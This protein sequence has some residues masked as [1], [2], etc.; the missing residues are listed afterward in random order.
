M[1]Y[2]FLVLLLLGIS[3][4]GDAALP[5]EQVPVTT[6]AN[7]Q[8]AAPTPPS[9]PTTPITTAPQP[10]APSPSTTPEGDGTMTMENLD[11]VQVTMNPSLFLSSEELLKKVQQSIIPVYKNWVL[12]KN[13]TY[14]ILDDVSNIPDVAQ[15]ALRLLAT[16]RPKSVL[17]K[18]TWDYSISHL[19]RV[20]GWSVYGNGYGIYT[21]VHPDEMMDAP[22]PPTIIVFSRNKRSLDEANPQ[23][24]YISSAEGIR[25]YQ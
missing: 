7:P 1:P 6:T 13:G 8:P 19:E 12:F 16:Y 9:V 18:P 5:S 17:E 15:E 21:Y 20:E 11:Q 23:I 24:L 14:I 4:C 2:I 22:A 3:A 10:V 25:A